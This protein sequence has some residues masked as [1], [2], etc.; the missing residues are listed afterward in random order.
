VARTRLVISPTN[1]LL[2]LPAPLRLRRGDPPYHPYRNHHDRSLK[3]LPRLVSFG[4][5]VV[6]SGDP[7]EQEKQLKYAPLTWS[8]A[9]ALTPSISAALSNTFSIGRPAR[10]PRAA[11]TAVRGGLV[12]TF[13]TYPQPTPSPPTAVPANRHWRRPASFRLSV[14]GRLQTL[15]GGSRMIGCATS[16]SCGLAG[17]RSRG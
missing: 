7:V 13:Y 11:A 16:L 6:K 5:P 10:D 2:A 14:A 12:T 17:T 4:G 8:R 1:P 3:R 9:S 15:P